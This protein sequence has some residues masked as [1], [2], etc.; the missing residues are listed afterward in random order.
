MTMMTVDRDFPGCPVQ[1][2]LLKRK[3][4]GNPNT[5][6]SSSSTS[7]AVD[8]LVYPLEAREEERNESRD[9]T[10][11][12]LLGAGCLHAWL[13]EQ[14]VDSVDMQVILSVAR[15]NCAAD[16]IQSVC[17]RS[18][19]CLCVCVYVYRRSS[20]LHPAAAAPISGP[21]D[22]VSV[23]VLFLSIRKQS[24]MHVRF[25]CD[26]PTVVSAQ[27]TANYPFVGS[28]RI[29]STFFS[30]CGPACLPACPVRISPKKTKIKTPM[31]AWDADLTPEA[32]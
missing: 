31:P 7:S 12:W 6:T 18:D 17:L 27:R 15:T 32:T 21:G 14:T 30:L 25:K 20:L 4:K 1:E 8:R 5:T 11:P 29:H 19:L 24:S 22:R 28:R 16:R 26:C 9:I 2:I 13:G 23:C 3:K 10:L